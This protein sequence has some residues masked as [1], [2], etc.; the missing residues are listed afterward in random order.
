MRGVVMV[1]EK[2]FFKYCQGQNYY[3]CKGEQLPV[4]K[5]QHKS[6]I[7]KVMFLATVA[8]L[9]WNMHRNCNFDGKIGTFPF[10]WQVQAQ[11]SSGNKAAGTVVTKMVEVLKE[12]YKWKMLDE[13]FPT[14]KRK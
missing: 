7:E 8:Q 12:V 2:W 5:V 13:I 11:R 3:L 1:D 9:H 4:Y 14:T 6:H 10:V